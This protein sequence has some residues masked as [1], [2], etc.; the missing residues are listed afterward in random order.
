MPADRASES[1]FV[2]VLRQLAAGVG[3]GLKSGW[4][5]HPAKLPNSFAGGASSTN[6]V[7]VLVLMVSL[8][9]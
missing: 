3:Q 4:A 9:V 2:Q 5:F 6:L 8:P 1:L 7:T